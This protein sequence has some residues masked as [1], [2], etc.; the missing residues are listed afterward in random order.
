MAVPAGFRPR[1]P[2]RPEPG[3]APAG[4]RPWVTLMR[5]VHDE[6]YEE[7]DPAERPTVTA[8]AHAAHLSP[9]YVSECFSGKRRPSLKAFLSLVAALRGNPAEWEPRWRRADA[10]HPPPGEAEESLLPLPGV[11]D[12]DGGDSWGPGPAGGGPRPLPGPIR[13]LRRHP[14]RRLTR[15]LVA[16]V[17]L[18]FTWHRRISRDRHAMRLRRKLVKEVRDRTG[19]HLRPA[20]V[21][22][23]LRPRF[24]ILTERREEGLARGR[25][26]R[27]ARRAEPQATATLVTSIRALYEDTDDLVV[28]GR[29]GMGKTTQL[30]RLAHRL[31]MEVLEGGDDQGLPHVPVFLRLDTYRGEPAEDWLVSAMSREYGVSGALVRTWLSEHRLLPVLD[32]LDE[33]AEAGPVHMRRGTAPAAAR[34]PRHGRGLPH[35]RGGPAPSG[36]RSPRP[37]LRRDPAP[38]PAG[39]AELPRRRP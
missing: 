28:L 11:D 13:P 24:L 7:L 36:F 14:L 25:R 15:T 29:P 10:E 39:R 12:E 31:A 38:E 35:G 30:A 22:H 5:G 18:A 16:W 27:R 6:L 8:L 3:A 33:V 1:G 34:L 4:L 37:A 32:G 23:Y 2:R 21:H 17:V 9:S 26:G 19:E 20:E